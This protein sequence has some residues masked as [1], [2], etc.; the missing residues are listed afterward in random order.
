MLPEG[1]LE[2]RRKPHRLPDHAYCTPGYA[3]GITIRARETTPDL[4]CGD[5]PDIVTDAL[6][7]AAEHHRCAIVAHCLLPD[8]LHYL[9]CVPDTDGHVIRGLS[10]FKQYIA[11]VLHQR[12]AP[13]P[14][15][16][17]G[18]W[19]RHVRDSEDL[20]RVIWYIVRNP[21]HHGLCADP[22]EWPYSEQ[23]GWPDRP[24]PTS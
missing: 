16:V 6:Y 2:P 24:G 19:D 1:E 18:F 12:G 17:R 3:I 5:I 13:K 11:R 9:A 8:H 22:R 20:S 4:T 15:W 10:S 23:R 21:V 14:V 7:T